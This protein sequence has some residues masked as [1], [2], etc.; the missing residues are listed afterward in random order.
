MEKTTAQ[1]F[2]SY[3]HRNRAV[4]DRIAA[5]IEKTGE[6]SVWYDKGLIPG[7]EYRKR[8]VTNI[9]AADFFIV[10]LSKSSVCSEWVLDEVEYAKQQR[11]R[12][13]SVAIMYGMNAEA[14]RH[15]V[16][17]S[18]ARAA[19][20]ITEGGLQLAQ[21]IYERHVVLS[22]VLMRLGVSE[23]TALQDACRIEHVISDETF[24]ALKKHSECR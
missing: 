2:I 22:N 19:V 17:Q 6:L 16:S 23:E 21:K 4:C 24:E 10:L 5:A 1:V 3:S 8:I 20:Y 14:L 15:R 12:G 7:E 13:I 9:Q 18:L 11:K